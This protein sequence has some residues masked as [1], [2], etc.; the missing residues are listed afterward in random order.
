MSTTSGPEPRQFPVTGMMAIVLMVSVN[1]L[2]RAVLLLANRQFISSIGL[3]LSPALLILVSLAW[4]LVGLGL[5]RAL[6]TGRHGALRALQ[7]YAV[8]YA[9]YV[10]VDRL[11]LNQNPFT[12][13]NQN[14]AVA[15][16]LLF[17]GFIFWGTTR[18]QT[19][20]FYG[21]NNE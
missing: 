21:E 6:L 17:L 9:F 20:L 16:T 10:W 5:L 15:L 13:A 11:A 4:G 3:S 7:V 19:R 8:L 18:K 2:L 12:Q 1:Q 14:F